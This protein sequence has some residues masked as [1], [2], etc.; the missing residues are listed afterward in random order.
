[1]AVF[2]IDHET[3]LQNFLCKDDKNSSKRLIGL[4]PIPTKD[5]LIKFY[6]DENCTFFKM[7]RSIQF[8]DELALNIFVT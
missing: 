7:Y 1:M 6:V 5:H 2:I 4:S 8:L 3:Q